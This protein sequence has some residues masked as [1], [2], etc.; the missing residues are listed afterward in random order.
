MDEGSNRNPGTCC[1]PWG[2]VASLPPCSC[3]GWTRL[4]KAL[5]HILGHALGHCFCPSWRFVLF[6]FL[7]LSQLLSGFLGAHFSLGSWKTSC[8][9]WDKND[10]LLEKCWKWCNR[11]STYWLS[12]KHTLTHMQ[13]LPECTHVLH[14]RWPELMLPSITQISPPTPTH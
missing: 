12:C 9:T 14:A 7:N 2:P 1:C 4:I 8:D 6:F 5:F 13:Y 10:M 11:A 3:M